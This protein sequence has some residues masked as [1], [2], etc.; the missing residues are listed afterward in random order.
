M[1]AGPRRA[2]TLLPGTSRAALGLAGVT[3][4]GRVLLVIVAVAFGV[5]VAYVAI[6]KAGPCPVLLADGT[7]IG[8]SP[9]ACVRGDE[10]FY[11]AE[12]NSVAAGHGFEEPLSAF[13]HPGEKPPPAADHPPLTVLVLTPVAWLA[14]HAPFDW[15]IREPL[16]D[17]VRE[18]RYAMALLGTLLVALVGLLGRRIGGDAV[19]LVAAAIAALS[20]NI[21]VNDGLV[22]S[23]TL[24]ALTVVGVLLGALWWRE[25]P[26]LRRAALVG[27]LCGLAL[28]ARVEFAL[29]VPLLVLVFAFTLTMSWAQRWKHAL[30]AVVVALAVVAPWVSFNLVRFKDPT[31]VSTNDGLTLAGANCDSVYYGPSTGFWSLACGADPGP[32]DQSQTS[33]A[34][35]RRGLDYLTHHTSRLPVVVL[36][37]L[38]RTWSVFRPLDMAR[39]NTGE[40]R[41]PWVTRLGLIAYYP[42]MVFAIAGAVVLWRRRARAV[43]WALLVPSIIVTINTVV[44]YGLPR[45]RAGAEPALALLA[46]VGV[47]ALA[48]RLRHPRPRHRRRARW[49][50]NNHEPDRDAAVAVRGCRPR[51]RRRPR[52]ATRDHGRG[53]DRVSL[54]P[55]GA[56]G[57]VPR[58]RRLLRRVRL[59]HRAPR[60]P[61][62]RAF[63]H[64]VA[65]LVLG[66]TGASP[67]PG[68]G[69]RHHRGVGGG[70]RQALQR[71][72]PRHPR[73]GARH[74][75][76]LART[77]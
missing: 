16:H 12:S 18:D 69:D 26:S 13:T 23:E 29:L 70:G 6:A 36:A 3:R 75:V 32:G 77:G 44:T 31:F 60:H 33:S 42:T 22:M 47:V 39:L 34:L 57:G 37:R 2:S 30:A 5:R 51:V 52:R 14:E 15:V 1:G 4:F 9:S 66:A 28:L 59:S 17:H 41:E 25:R 20:P 10:L 58:R 50:A 76:L 71:R 61:R 64:G 24:T 53:C 45:F 49:R 63:G 40:D 55:V 19:G 46:A 67:A 27:A 68:S 8:S 21:W 74:P 48:G 43:L 65:R 73:P 7:K 38:G 56:A 11:N 35:R 54:R 72:D 62:D